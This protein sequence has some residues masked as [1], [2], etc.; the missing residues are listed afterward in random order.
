MAER[1]CIVCKKKFEQ[2]DL[3]RIVFNN[4]QISV[5]N[6]KKIDGRGAYVCKNTAC[7]ENLLKQRALNR[8]FK[9]NISL[10]EYEKLLNILKN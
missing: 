4:G 10:E 1:T 3:I 5:Q 2:P 9:C 7:H 8:T 6:G